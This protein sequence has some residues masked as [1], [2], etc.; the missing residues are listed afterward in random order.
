MKKLIGM[1]NLYF[2]RV[3]MAEIEAE[4]ERGRS[5][6]TTAKIVKTFVYVP[7]GLLLIST[8]GFW[9]FMKYIGAPL[10]PTITAIVVNVVL[11]GAF[12]VYNEIVRRKIVAYIHTLRHYAVVVLSEPESCSTVEI[13]AEM[14]RKGLRPVTHEE[15]L[16]FGQQ[17]DR[18][19]N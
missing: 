7:I 8:L 16:D 13:L 5:M 6:E 14:E 15:L 10:A 19:E 3:A 2:E 1:L 12:I 17:H 11:M 9:L 18:D 4:W